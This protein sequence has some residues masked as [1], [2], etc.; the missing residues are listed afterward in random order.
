MFA[1]ADMAD[2]Y[3]RHGNDAQLNWV[4]P[5]E[6]WVHNAADVRI[7][8]RCA[9]NT[10]RGSSLDRATLVAEM[11]RTAGKSARLVR[12]ELSDAQSREMRRSI[13]FTPKQPLAQEASFAL[14]EIS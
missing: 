1:D 3:L 5:L 2:F 13:R 14:A 8:V 6:D 10:R 11:L 7:I 9:T 12:A 4:S